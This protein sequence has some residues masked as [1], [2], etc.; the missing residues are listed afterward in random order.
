MALELVQGQGTP[1]ADDLVIR[2]DGVYAGNYLGNINFKQ[3][4]F[5][6]SFCAQNYDSNDLF[7]LNTCGGD[8]A[9][10]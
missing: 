8:N 5:G 10:D 4:V 3:S 1:I 2:T 7:K 6:Q 9:A